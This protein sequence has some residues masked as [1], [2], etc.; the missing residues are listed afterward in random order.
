MRMPQG[1]VQ[2]MPRVVASRAHGQHR[3]TGIQISAVLCS[4]W[5]HAPW[6]ARYAQGASPVARACVLRHLCAAWL[7]APNPN[8]NLH[9]PFDRSPTPPLCPTQRQRPS[10]PRYMSYMQRALQPSIELRTVSRL[11]SEKV[12][13]R[14]QSLSV[15]PRLPSAT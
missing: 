11:I 1:S 15:A 4:P 9:A 8:P 7:D 5:H 14:D 12:K 10:G 6:H 3:A 2:C 13:N